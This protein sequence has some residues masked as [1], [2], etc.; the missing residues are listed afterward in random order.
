[1]KENKIKQNIIDE[2]IAGN[3]ESFREIYEVTKNMIYNVV[4]RI[5]LNEEDAQD[6]TH[7]VYIKAFEKR[8]NYRREAE[9]Q[10]WIY[11]IA[12]NQARNYLRRKRWFF[13]KQ[14]KIKENLYTET[15][16]NLED[17]VEREQVSRIKKL[18][19][20]VQQNYRVCV[21]L[22]D[23]EHLSYEEIAEV[24]KINIGT[25]RSRISRGRKA[26]VNIHKK[27]MGFYEMPRG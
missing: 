10:T 7:D 1:M 19:D 8:E 23:I 11:S 5:V 15:S 2:F 12:V 18:L 27:E 22:R 13:S 16:E 14:D 9:I 25:V 26:L 24:L 4:Y 3:K 17:D 20:Q 6:I 21:V